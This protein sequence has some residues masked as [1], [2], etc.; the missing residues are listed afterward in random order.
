L[1]GF[2]FCSSFSTPFSVIVISGI[3]LKTSFSLAFPCLCQWWKLI[4][5]AC[6]IG[7]SCLEFHLLFLRRLLRLVLH[8]ILS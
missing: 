8:L 3:S 7:L 6:L 4:E 5:T 2:R 1:F